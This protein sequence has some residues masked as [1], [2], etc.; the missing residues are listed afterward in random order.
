M[1]RLVIVVE[2]RARRPGSSLYLVT[3]F[4][5]EALVGNVGSLAPGVLDRTGWAETLYRRQD[6]TEG[7]EHQALVRGVQLP[8]G[9]RLLVG[10]DLGVRE[11]LQEVDL[12]GGRWSIARVVILGL[13]G[14][15]LV[16]RRVL[17]RVDAMTETTRAIMAGNLAG[18]LAIAGTGDEL[19]RLAS[20]LNAMLERI[21]ALMR[22]L[23]EV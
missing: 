18:R 17:R 5:G 21:E 14:G 7:A 8:G 20:N 19:D 22:G 15:L 13:A 3:T 6:E 10:R 2:S 1:R 16:T 4:T 11:G 23:K 12:D 9:F